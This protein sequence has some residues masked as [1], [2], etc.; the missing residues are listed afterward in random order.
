MNTKSIRIEIDNRTP[1]S[2][3]VHP[4]QDS[5]G[6]PRVQSSSVRNF[7]I[8]GASSEEYSRAVCTAI[9]ALS[10]F[11]AHNSCARV[12]APTNVSTLSPTIEGIDSQ[13]T[14]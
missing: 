9:R 10:V 3:V 13:G 11:D 4:D 2:I 14:W 1:I 12:S 5:D 6:I 7:N 8:A